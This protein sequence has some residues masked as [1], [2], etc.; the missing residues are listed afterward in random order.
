MLAL[1]SPIVRYREIAAR[2]ALG[3]E[4]SV[5]DML[6]MTELERRHGSE[7]VHIKGVLRVE[8]KEDPLTVTALGLHG[9][10]CEEAQWIDVGGPAELTIADGDFVYLFKV[11]ATWTD[12]RADGSLDVALDFIGSPVVLH[13]GPKSYRQT[14][15]QS[16]LSRI[17]A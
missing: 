3:L 2:C 8:G 12:D 14:I 10:M 9:V 15:D 17:A 1:F 6:A 4:L 16:L 5:D 7:R 13:R 11:R